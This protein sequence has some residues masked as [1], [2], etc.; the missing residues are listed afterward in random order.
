[1][2]CKFSLSRISPKMGII[3]ESRFLLLIIARHSLS[4]AKRLYSDSSNK[5]IFLGLQ[6]SNCRVISAPMEPPAPE[7]KKFL[8]LRLL[9]Q[10]LIFLFR[11]E[12]HPLTVLADQSFFSDPKL[13][14]LLMEQ[15]LLQ[16]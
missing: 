16:L 10:H 13:T 15:F 9:V 14:Q 8:T 12:Y 6:S 11:E 1:M 4:I 7:T 2:Y 3:K 5:I